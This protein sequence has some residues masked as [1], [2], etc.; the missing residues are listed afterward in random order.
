MP[1]EPSLF[2][3]V[4]NDVGG[5]RQGQE[6]AKK[7][8]ACGIKHIRIFDPAT[9]WPECIPSEKDAAALILG[10]DTAPGAHRAAVARSDARRALEAQPFVWPLHKSR[11]NSFV[12]DGIAG[13]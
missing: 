7:A 10:D 13:N 6:K 4:D 1:F 9:V 5:R 8:Y 3:V 2:S 11:L 12:A